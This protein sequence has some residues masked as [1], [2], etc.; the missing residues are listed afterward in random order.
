MPWSGNH[1]P[2]CTVINTVGHFQAQRGFAM[3]KQE[4]APATTDDTQSGTVVQHSLTEQF[5]AYM[6]QR[7]R[8]NGAID[9]G[10]EVMDAQAAAILGAESVED[11]L[12]AD[13][14]GTVQCKN[15]PGTYWRI[16]SLMPVVSNRTDIENQKGYYIQFDATLIGGDPDI[17]ARSGLEVGGTYPLQTGAELLC[18]KA[19]AL[20]AKNAFPMDLALVGIKTASN[21]LVLKWGKMPVT[22][23]QGNVA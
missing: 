19:R 13:M 4:T 21:R 6:L 20:E 9:R 5:H 22:V 7:A 16:R 12:A 15:V 8:D 17:I 10:D 2:I 1:R 14:G 3:A 18:I 23:M 11:I